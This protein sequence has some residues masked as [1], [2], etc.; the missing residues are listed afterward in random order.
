VVIKSRVD[1]LCIES[2]AIMEVMDAA[3]KQV[4]VEYAEPITSGRFNNNS[5]LSTGRTHS[6]TVSQ[7]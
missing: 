5:R 3:L 1:L 4:D 6:R 2:I 7:L